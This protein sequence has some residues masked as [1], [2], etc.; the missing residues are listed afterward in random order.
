MPV[1]FYRIFVTV[2]WGCRLFP[3]IFHSTLRCNFS[4]WFN[5]FVQLNQPCR[6][7][8]RRKHGRNYKRL[9]SQFKHRNPSNI[10]W[11]NCIRL[12]KI[13]AVIKWILNCTQNWRHSPNRMSNWTSKLSSPTQ[14]INWYVNIWLLG[15]VQHLKIWHFN[16]LIGIFFRQVYLKKMDECWQSHCQQMIMIRSIFLYLDRTY[17]LQN[18]TVHSIW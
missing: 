10:R 15:N 8:T 2:S 7:I 14:M 11:K 1:S 3:L 5:L 4:M 12:W 6:I 9:L 17:V 13:C 16:I 18:P